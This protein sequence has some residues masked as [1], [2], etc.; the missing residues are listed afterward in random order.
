MVSWDSFSWTPFANP[1]FDLLCSRG[2][3]QAELWASQTQK[4]LRL[5]KLPGSLG[6][7]KHWVHS[8][9][10][11]K[12]QSWPMATLVPRS[13][14]LPNQPS[15][16]SVG[17]EISGSAAQQKACGLTL[18]ICVYVLINNLEIRIMDLELYL[19]VFQFKASSISKICVGREKK[20]A[21]PG[22]FCA[23]SFQQ[24]PVFCS[25][26]CSDCRNL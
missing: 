5:K 25:V 11:G 12:A 24:K 18:T 4:V 20:N 9:Q 16:W 10:E 13:S 6:C 8:A 1:Q 17:T 2:R 14:P 26:K 19:M 23:L 15:S 22:C 3:L 7:K 21:F